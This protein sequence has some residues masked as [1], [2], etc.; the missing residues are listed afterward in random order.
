MSKVLL[1]LTLQGWWCSLTRSYSL[2]QL[3]TLYLSEV[4][5]L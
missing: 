1:I 2:T 5:E 4:P 3:V